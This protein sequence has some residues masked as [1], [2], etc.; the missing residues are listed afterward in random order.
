MEKMLW[1]LFA[2]PILVLIWGTYDYIKSGK[3]IKKIR[4]DIKRQIDNL[5]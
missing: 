4:E 3:E 2:I 1:L 5:L